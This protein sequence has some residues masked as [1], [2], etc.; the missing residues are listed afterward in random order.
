MPSGVPISR[1]AARPQKARQAT[2][3]GPG[4]CWRGGFQCVSCVHS[5]YL[6]RLLFRQR[7]L[8]A[9][10]PWVLVL[11]RWWII[12][13]RCMWRDRP[14]ARGDTILTGL[15]NV[16]LMATMVRTGLSA[17]SLL[18][19]AHGSRGG[20]EHLG[21]GVGAI[22]GAAGA[23]GTLTGATDTAMALVTPAAMP[24]GMPMDSI[25]AIAME[26]PG[27]HHNRA[28]VALTMDSGMAALMA[29]TH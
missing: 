25:M 24:M 2:P 9:R 20:M 22:L 26:E 28:R 8:T 21:A 19:P 18:G 16:R 10:L 4:N 5:R 23:G 13:P 6:R 7:L 11:A 15:M 29:H 3:V 17:E 12:P 27:E 1:A 14:S